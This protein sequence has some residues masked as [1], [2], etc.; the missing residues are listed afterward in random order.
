M[1][2][3]LPHLGPPW[4]QQ[5]GR[6]NTQLDSKDQVPGLVPLPHSLLFLD[7]SFPP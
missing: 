4:A 6:D 1:L 5:W 2:A 3:L 7:L